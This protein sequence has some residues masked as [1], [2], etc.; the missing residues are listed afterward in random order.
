MQSKELEAS[1]DDM[2]GKI[3]D[4]GEAS[5]LWKQLGGFRR[6][7]TKSKEFTTDEEALRAAFVCCARAKPLALCRS[8]LQGSAML[9]YM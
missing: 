6:N 7:R 9:S 4:I 1:L 3:N 8:I 2:K 5:K